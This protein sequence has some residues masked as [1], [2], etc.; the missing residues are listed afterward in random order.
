MAFSLCAQTLQR[1]LARND[2]TGTSYCILECVC[3]KVGWGGGGGG[4][5]GGRERK[6]E[7]E[8]LVTSQADTDT[9]INR[10]NTFHRQQKSLIQYVCPQLS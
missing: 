1:S 9:C 8:Q 5:G 7:R 3:V 10:I 2:G 6:R 4:G